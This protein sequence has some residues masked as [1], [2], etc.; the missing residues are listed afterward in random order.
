M[1][2][3][4]TTSTVSDTVRQPAM[5]RFKRMCVLCGSSQGKKTTYRDAAIDLAKQLVSRGIDLVYGGGSTGLMKL[6][7]EAVY[8]GGK[9]KQVTRENILKGGMTVC[10]QIPGDTTLREVMLVTDMH[11]MKADMVR[12]SDAFIALPGGF[13]TLE[14]L[15]EVISW[16]QLGIHSKPIGVLNVDGYYDF[17]LTFIDKAMWEGFIS[18]S[19]RRII[20]SAPTA[21]ELLDNLEEYVP[22]YD[23]VASELKWE[24]KIKD[25]AGAEGMMRK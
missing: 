9:G 8:N 1:A 5:S 20:I 7:S 23:S 12:Q 10:C 11:Q 19:A 3:S 22:Y 2:A 16:A 18:P 24:M 14:Q 4:I 13:G 15:L 6:I 25:D 17:L 21:L